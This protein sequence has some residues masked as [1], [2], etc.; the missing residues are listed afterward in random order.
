MKDQQYNLIPAMHDISN[1]W[2]LYLC[3]SSLGIKRIEKHMVWIIVKNRK[4]RTF[5]LSCVYVYCSVI[6]DEMGFT[7]TILLFTLFIK[8]LKISFLHYCLLFW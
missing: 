3:S 8:F 6:T 7:Y 5:L 2:G 4:M 1:V